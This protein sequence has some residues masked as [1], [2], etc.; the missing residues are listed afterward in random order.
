VHFYIGRVTSIAVLAEAIRLDMPASAHLLNGAAAS[1]ELSTVIWL[2]TEHSCAL[3][4]TSECSAG[5]GHIEVLRWLK[6]QGVIFSTDTMNSAAMH[7]QKSTCAYLQGESCP[8][9]EVTVFAAALAK[10]WDLV[11]WLHEHGCPW[12]PYE[13]CLIA[14]EQGSIENM[15]FI[16]QRD[17]V[18]PHTLSTLLNAA[19]AN[20]HLAAAQWLR[21][22]DAQWPD[23]LW[24]GGTSWS[25]DILEWARAEGFDSPLHF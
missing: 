21:Q 3:N 2:H 12:Y 6:Q 18:S 1:D 15:T 24:Y 17:V 8:W 23:S 4:T 13:V 10:H 14:A 11:R 22:R 9:D 19:G 16:L 7:G 25:G 5:E 20:G